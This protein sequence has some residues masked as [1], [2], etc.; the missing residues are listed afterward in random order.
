MLGKCLSLF[1]VI[2]CFSG[3]FAH[4]ETHKLWTDNEQFAARGAQSL[5]ITHGIEEA[6]QL[7]LNT[8]A[9]EALLLTPAHS[10]EFAARSNVSI[11]IELPLPDG[12]STTVTITPTKLLPPLLAD[13]YPA[14]RTY[15]VSSEN[16]EILSGRLDYTSQGFHAMLLSRQGETILIDPK[17][18]HG[19][20]DY[21]SYLKSDQ[22]T[23]DHPHQCSTPEAHD[24]SISANLHSRSSLAAR[25]SNGLMEYRIAVAATAEY[26]ARQG[27]TVEST[28]SAI[29][30]TLSRVNQVYEQSLGV[31][32]RLVE[33]NDQLIY[34][35]SSTDPYSN[36]DIES[37]LTAN[38]TNIDR[39]IGN[40]NYDIGHVFGTSGGGLAFIGSLCNNS[41]KAMAASGI[42]SPYGDS[43][44]ID[45]VAHELGHQFGATH[46]FNGT[47]G[48]CT[49]GARTARS[50]FE[51]GSGSSIMSYAGGC[52]TDDLQ[53]NADA[54]FHSGNIQQ[55]QLNLMSGVGSTCGT[56][57]SST[58][59]PP[60]IS[61]GADYTIPANTPFELTA[62]ATDP[63]GDSLLYS[64]EQA[65]T[66]T[67]AT[68]KTD[69]GD[70]PLFRIFTPSQNQSR[71]FPSMKTLTGQ[72]YI[73][74]ELLPQSDRV[75]KFQVAVYDNHNPAT[76]DQ[77]FITVAN[78]GESF[79]LESPPIGYQQDSYTNIRWNTGN[80][81]YAPVSCPTVDL[82][83][84][85]DNGNNFDYVIAE[86]L[87]NS[88]SAMV[89]LP[90]NLP[91]STT[92]RFKLSCASNIFFSVS[93]QKFSISR[94]LVLPA[95]TPRSDEITLNDQNSSQSGGGSVNPL[96]LILILSLFLINKRPFS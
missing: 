2:T 61:A 9:M 21:L 49:S 54:M 79:S 24:H 55:I 48:I 60:V 64:W 70:N 85:T 96:L 57:H 23:G 78:S 47:L 19:G 30:T 81:Q 82:H 3:V 76:I 29:V 8:S 73:S 45:F 43:F 77:T 91:D 37:M 68:L 94:E 4:D 34:T 40:D 75:M 62:T 5:L 52:G 67:A 42:N 86:G 15:K 74:G 59:V 65:D 83:L 92:A 63:D 87:N 14:I 25:G 6:R 39:I 66:G 71:S 93:S 56:Y 12:Q 11:N 27:G 89:Y 13:K 36:F 17:S 7:S 16:S 26:T 38:Q 69:T 53:H 90:S 18:K 88:G 22:H 28:L 58:N 72:E 31:R 1:A 20:S 51:P 33:N 32:L 84:S 35:E 95:E 50:A 44:D 41:R 80:T 10:T 46:T